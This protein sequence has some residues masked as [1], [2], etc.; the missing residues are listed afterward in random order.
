MLFR[1]WLICFHLINKKGGSFLWCQ[2]FLAI[3]CVCADKPAHSA[4]RRA[5]TANISTVQNTVFHCIQ[6]PRYIPISFWLPI[7]SPSSAE[8]KCA[9][10]QYKFIFYNFNTCA[11]FSYLYILKNRFC[12]VFFVTLQSCTGPE[13]GFPCVVILTGKNL[14][15][16]QGTPLLIAGILYSLQGIPCVN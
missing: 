12:I 15:S 13:Q 2:Q 9:H 14:F 10:C 5:Y 8:V 6:T 7:T 11:V 1:E 4:P 3:L 16:L